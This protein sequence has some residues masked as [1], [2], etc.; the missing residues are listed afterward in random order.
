MTVRPIM[1]LSNGGSTPPARSPVLFDA[2]GQGLLRLP[3]A[4]AKLRTTNF[5]MPEVVV[6]QL[7]K[8]DA[9]RQ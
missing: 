7:L 6:K 4:I 5:R 8:L 2:A 3:E 9:Q 1:P